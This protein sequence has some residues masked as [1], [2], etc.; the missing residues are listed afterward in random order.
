LH[1]DVKMS[2]LILFLCAI[3]IA[4]TFAF[5]HCVDVRGKIRCRNDAR[6]DFTMFLWSPDAADVRIAKMIGD[7]TV[8]DSSGT[9][10]VSG[11]IDT[12]SSSGLTPYF[13]VAHKCPGNYER[14]FVNVACAEGIC[15]HVDIDIGCP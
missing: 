14:D 6:S 13:L 1:F 4:T 10:R 11:C 9:Y 2:K 15:D 3:S 5:Q 12:G 8:V 7:K